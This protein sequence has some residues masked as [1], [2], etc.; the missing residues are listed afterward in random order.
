MQA[1]GKAA[2]QR[3]GFN[4]ISHVP[5][6]VLREMGYLCGKMRESDNLNR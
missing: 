4:T 3:Y 6:T 2:A 1:D 5:E